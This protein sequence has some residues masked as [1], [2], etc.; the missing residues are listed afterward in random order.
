MDKSFLQDMHEERIAKE[1]R[2]SLGNSLLLATA[3][4]KNMQQ[5]MNAVLSN[6]AV[7]A[8]QNSQVGQFS[9]WQ[10]YNNSYNMAKSVFEPYMKNSE[11]K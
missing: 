6:L 9:H 5:A 8:E 10:A 2:D 11:G 1:E 3:F 4:I 7:S